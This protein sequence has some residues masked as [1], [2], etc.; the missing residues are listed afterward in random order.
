[1]NCP[2]ADC[3]KRATVMQTRTRDAYVYRRYVCAGGHRFSTVQTGDGELC[4]DP[5]MAKRIRK[6]DIIRTIK[7]SL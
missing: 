4:C 3:A 7:A 6:S 5:G 2:E 1:M